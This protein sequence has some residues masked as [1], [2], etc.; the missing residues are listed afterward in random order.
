MGSLDAAS[1]AVIVEE[2][3]DELVR[4]VVRL[5]AGSSAA[6]AVIV[7]EGEDELVRWVVRLLVGS[8]WSVPAGSSNLESKAHHH[9]L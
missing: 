3:E 5:L 7:E 9:A 1:E 2:G 6:R 8:W 4:W